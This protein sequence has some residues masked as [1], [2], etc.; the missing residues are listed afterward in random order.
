[1]NFAH[2]NKSSPHPSGSAVI[3]GANDLLNAQVQKIRELEE[4]IQ[5]RDHSL[6]GILSQ[7][8][9][10]HLQNQLLSLSTNSKGKKTKHTLTQKKSFNRKSNQNA[11]MIC[12]QKSKLEYIKKAKK[13]SQKSQKKPSPH[14]L[15]TQE[16]PE[17]FQP[18]KVCVQFPFVSSPYFY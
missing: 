4:Q 6:E 17:E 12:N 2:H 7:V 14:Q 9:N 3:S 10:L 5:F 8:N 11:G 15:T 18:V 13:K 1:M 16:V